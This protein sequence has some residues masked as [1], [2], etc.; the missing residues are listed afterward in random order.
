MFKLTFE[1][2]FK[3]IEIFLEENGIKYFP[4]RKEL[5]GKKKILP[6]ENLNT[7]DYLNS[8]QCV[9]ILCGI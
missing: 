8:I 1:E 3:S 4:F 7:R 5:Y 6:Q 9:A 2:W